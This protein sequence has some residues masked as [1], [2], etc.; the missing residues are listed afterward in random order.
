[1]WYL[2]NPIAAALAALPVLA[3]IYFLFGRRSARSP[4]LIALSVP[5]EIWKPRSRLTKWIFRALFASALLA[6]VAMG[7]VIARPTQVTAWVEK[8]SEGIDIVL[9]V[10]LSESMEATDF[11][12]SRMV[13]AKA[14]I[15]DFIRRRS[16]DRIGLVAFGG[17]AVTKCPLTRDYDFLLTS[18]EEMGSGE[19][20]QG[21]AIGMGLANAVGRLRNSKAKTRVVILLT[22]GDS[23]VGAVNPITASLLARQEGI[24]VYTIGIGKSDRVL[25]PIYS[26]DPFG[27]KRQLVAQ[28]PSYLN[29]ELLK[30]ISRLTG[31]KA[32][33]ARDP[34]M[35]NR[36]L[37]EIDSLEKTK[38]RGI[39]RERK[40]EVFFWPALA[41]TLLMFLVYV[42]QETRFRKA[43][44]RHASAF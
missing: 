21:T 43:R 1:M 39:P 25:V 6:L 9:V 10:D 42:L 27:R 40:D 31:G 19:L 20:K 14:V 24:K 3:A 35:L 28:V 5:K 26:H 7:T 8:W 30:E 13:A 16:E 18:V 44:L 22:D 41:A 11:E 12:P 23:N 37:R 38:V 29:P 4:Q 17:E 34:G 32:Y 36:I 33:L 2:A 15:R